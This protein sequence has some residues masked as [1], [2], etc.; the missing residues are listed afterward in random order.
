MRFCFLMPQ[1]EH[2][3]PVSGGAIATVTANVAHELERGGDCVDVIAPDCGEPTYRRGKLHLVNVHKAGALREIAAHLEARLRRWHFPHEGRFFSKSLQTLG[4]VSPDVVV[5]ANDLERISLVRRLLPRSKVVVWLHNECR[6]RKGSGSRLSDADAFLC[7][8]D[9]IKRWFVAEYDIPSA[10]VYTAYA[11]IDRSAFY[12]E[13]DDP[14][15]KELRLLFTGRLDPNKGVDIAVD[16]VLRLRAMGL[17]IQLSI[18]GNIWFYGQGN[19]YRDAFQCRLRAAMGA[20]GIDWLGHVPRRFLPRVMRQHDVGLVLSRSDEPFGLVVLE[21]MAS[22]LAVLASP[23]GGLPEACSGA[24]ILVE[25]NNTTEIERVLHRLCEDRDE[26]RRWKKR[27]LSRVQ[28][29]SWSATAWALRRAV[30]SRTNGCD[31]IGLADSQPVA[32]RDLCKSGAFK[33]A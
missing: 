11:G 19:A 22:G 26:L 12:P 15:Q 17:P 31:S 20:D 23:R 27:S 4:R 33:T 16:S 21:S 10:R 5:L 18:A 7:C 25:P 30:E 14:D 28:S 29:A 9:H 6:L 32:G 24:A 8:S 3:S 2:Y 1:L 13:A